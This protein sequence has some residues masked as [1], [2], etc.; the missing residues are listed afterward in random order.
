M[1]QADY[2]TE[3]VNTQSFDG[4]EQVGQNTK[5]KCEA[6]C[7][8]LPTCQAF[9]YNTIDTSCFSHSDGYLSANLLFEGG[10]TGINQYRR[11]RCATAT[12]TAAVSSP[13]TRKFGLVILYSHFTLH[14]LDFYLGKKLICT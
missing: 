7:T 4:T 6:A 5:A 10:A 13:S 12:S 3:V 9:D 1:C 8:A 2:Y 14:I 11:V